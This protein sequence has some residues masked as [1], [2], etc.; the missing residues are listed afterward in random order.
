MVKNPIT[1]EQLIDYFKEDGTD[2]QVTFSDQEWDEYE[3]VSIS[4]RLLKPYMKNKIQCMGFEE[5]I[6]DKNATLLRV[7]IMVEDEVWITLSE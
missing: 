2:I 1:L 4:S 6:D 5:A 3:Q 7:T